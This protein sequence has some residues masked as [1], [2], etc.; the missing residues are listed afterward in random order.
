M[1]THHLALYSPGGIFLSELEWKNIDCTLAE[2]EVGVLTT[3]LFPYYYDNLFQRDCRLVYERS[4]LDGQVGWQVVGDTC[5]LLTG[6][7]RVLD[8]S[9]E[10]S[11]VLQFTHP[12]H[13]LSRRVNAYDESQTNANLS[14]VVSDAV[15]TLVVNNFT[16]A[17][18]TAR[19]LSGSHFAVDAALT[20]GPSVA[21]A[22]AYQ[23]VLEALR[24]LTDAAAAQ[25][26]YCGYEVYVPAYPGPYR[27][28][29]YLTLRGANRGLTSGHSI[30]ISPDTT[31]ITNASVSEDW[32]GIRSFAYAGGA[33]QRGEASVRTAEDTTLSGQSPFGR[34]EVF[35][36]FSTNDNTVLDSEAQHLL[37]Q[38]RPRRSYESTLHITPSGQGWQYGVD[39]S[40][41]DIVIAQFRAPVAQQGRGDVTAWID[42]AF[43]CR[44]DPVRITASRTYAYQQAPAPFPYLSGEESRSGPG[45]GNVGVPIFLDETETIDITLRSISSTT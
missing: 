17:T 25:G 8:E 12:N 34:S 6:R 41:G 15:R 4:P 31:N 19:N 24:Q 29:V 45:L 42:Y 44:V 16:T 39:F 13:I 7:E 35:Q 10:H 3:T 28:R 32:A 2:R 33:G 5:W 27:F 40:W 22:A 1:T 38:Y 36:S 11:I 9:G 30:A 21:K 14:A 43:D 26:T 23:N 18:D 20:S 37:R